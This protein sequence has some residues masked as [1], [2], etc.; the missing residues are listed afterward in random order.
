MVGK[1]TLTFATLAILIWASTATGFVAYY[2][3]QHLTDSEQLQQKQELLDEFSRNS[4]DSLTRWNLLAANYGSLHGDYQWSQEEN[5]ASLMGEYEKLIVNLKGNYTDLL[6]TSPDL[7]ETCTLLWQKYETLNQ[8][9]VIERNEFGELLSEFYK[10]F[11]SMALKEMGKSI[12]EV[13]IIQVSLLI[14]Y[15][16]TTRKWYNITATLGATLFNLTRTVAKIEYSY[17]STMEPGHILITSINDSAE[18]YWI[19]YNW[20]EDSGDWVFGPVGCDAWMLKDGGV[21]KWHQS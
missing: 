16:N 8:Q 21:Y 1:R 17:W 11:T 10:L 3:S 18:G 9:T 4:E 19:W 13:T 15:G 6:N 20:D 12:S 7:N 2:Y 14:D 5:Y